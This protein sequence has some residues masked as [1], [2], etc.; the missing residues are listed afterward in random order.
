MLNKSLLKK[1]VEKKT[2]AGKKPNRK[3]Q[4]GGI[5]RGTIFIVVIM[6]TLMFVGYIFV[7]GTIPEKIPAP[8]TEGIVSVDLKQKYP[9]ELGMQMHTFP[10]VTITPYP[11]EAPAAP[12]PDS[13]PV[14][15]LNCT[16][17]I[18]GTPLP[19][20]IWGYRIAATPP[21]GN[22]Q[23]LQV[24]FSGAEPVSIGTTAMTAKPV[25]HLTNPPANAGNRD[26]NGYPFSAA[27]F[28]TDIS[29]NSAD[30]SGDAKNG[31][32]AQFPSDVFGA[33][34]TEAAVKSDVPNGQYLGIDAD[35]WPP[36]NGPG[37]GAR[38]SVWTAELI[39]KTSALKTKTGASLTI[40]N[41]YRMQIIVHSGPKNDQIGM[42]CATFKL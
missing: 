14:I 40:G 8:R 24:F 32:L 3:I 42:A 28:I 18:I 4:R 22:Q 37:G 19:D 35:Y 15:E 33:W 21:S 1:G 26:P 23:S 17:S 7:G 39:W 36:A 38:K 31:G 10:G 9:Q 6:I 41:T 2:S 5:E 34:Q 20:L 16:D 25:Q 27:V 11:T 13:L 30:V 29:A 12:Q